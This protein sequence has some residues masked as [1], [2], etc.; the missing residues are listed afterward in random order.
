MAPG[1]P[2]LTHLMHARNSKAATAAGLTAQPALSEIEAT[3]VQGTPVQRQ[4]IYH[5]LS[6]FQTSLDGMKR[7][8]MKKRVPYSLPEMVKARTITSLCTARWN[9]QQRPMYSFGKRHV[10][11]FLLCAS[12]CIRRHFQKDGRLGLYTGAGAKFLA[13]WGSLED[14]QIVTHD[15]VGKTGTQLMEV[16]FS[17]TGATLRFDLF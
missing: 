6:Q 8:E 2:D 14:K 7:K 9:N 11:F 12:L 3:D 15:M 5:H 13:N 16:R 1:I 17:S 10:F 4:H